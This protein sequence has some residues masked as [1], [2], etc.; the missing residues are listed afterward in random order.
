MKSKS[1]CIL[2]SV[3]FIW[4][5]ALTAHQQAISE[6]AYNKIEELLSITEDQQTFENTFIP[7]VHLIR[8]EQLDAEIFYKSGLYYVVSAYAERSLSDHSLN[9][10]QK[11]LVEKFAAQTTKS[12]KA[13]S[14]TYING[15]TH[16]K[17][18]RGK[19][20]D[21]LTLNTMD[22]SDYEDLAQKA[23]SANADI[24]CFQEFDIENSTIYER[25]KNQ[26]AHFYLNI[27]EHLLIAS[28][29]QLDSPQVSQ[30][31]SSE[32]AFFDF[33]VKNEKDSI[34]HIYVAHLNLPEHT[35]QS[36]ALH[37]S[38]IIEK[39]DASFLYNLSGP[40]P[41]FLCGDLG[42]LRGSNEMGASLIDH[43]FYDLD[44]NL[45]SRYGLLLKTL[46]SFPNETLLQVYATENQVLSLENQQHALL[47]S[48]KI[49]E[50]PQF[51]NNLR[52]FYYDEPSIILCGS[53]KNR[54]RDN[55]A[56]VTAS[57]NSKGGGSV[58]GNVSSTSTDDKGNSTT[59]EATVE[60]KKDK[61]GKPEAEASASI[62]W[63]F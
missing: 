6:T 25:L 32:E 51:I 50:N 35:E 55:T 48:F 24:V 4:Q 28:K 12:D 19:D 57:A 8:L 5:L 27:A 2:G 39:M 46:P 61:N 36:H 40:I 14:F 16:S 15:E 41:H 54:E 56:E 63:K 3:F 59:C 49:N 47:T 29:Y 62:R 30:F 42:I 21:V 18:N 58:K 34:G 31:S 33:I 44:R 1:K 20:F 60:A 22:L 38:E 23:Q 17:I 37:L 7:F 13:N 52:S 10:Y 43:Y 26:Y 53:S 9:P 11:C 45:G